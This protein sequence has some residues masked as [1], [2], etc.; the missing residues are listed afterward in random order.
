MPGRALSWAAV[1]VLRS[2]GADEGAVAKPTVVAAAR[3]RIGKMQGNF[4]MGG[5][6]SV[7]SGDGSA[8]NMGSC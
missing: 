5:R 7:D 6:K 8:S 3:A 2:I 4:G 1:A